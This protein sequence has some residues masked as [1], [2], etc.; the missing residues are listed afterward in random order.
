MSDA[1]CARLREIEAE[2]A[3][4]VLPGDQRALALAHLN[5]CPVCRERL[6]ELT[7]VAEGLLGLVPPAE[8]PVGFEDRV[9]AGLGIGDRP[10]PLAGRRVRPKRQWIPLAVAA[11]V[12]ALVFGTLGWVVGHTTGTATTQAAPSTVTHHDLLEADLETADQHQ[13]GKVW[14]YLDKQS[15]LYVAVNAGQYTGSIECE[16]T[17][18]GGAPVDAGW[19]DLKD[20]KGEWGAP[21]PAQVPAGQIT[22]LSLRTGSGTVLAA[23]SLR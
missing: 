19:F 5:R 14:T 15:W 18:T 7:T 13:V 8:P 16:L 4:G 22:G 9:L 3:L 6:S 12:A 1:D 20:G 10:I 23:A 11:A 21:I 17:R 2:L